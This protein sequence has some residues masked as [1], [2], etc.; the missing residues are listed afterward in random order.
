M[1]LEQFFTKPNADN[2]NARVKYIIACLLLLVTLLVA[3]MIFK[4]SIMKSPVIVNTLLVTISILYLVY[5]TYMF[6]NLPNVQI[7]PGK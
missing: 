6:I 7:I 3:Q 5:G 4:V 1:D 2:I